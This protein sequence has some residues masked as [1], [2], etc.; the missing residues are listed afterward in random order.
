MAKTKQQF[1][2][3]CAS[4]SVVG[5]LQAGYTSFP[6][7]G[8]VT[9][10]I[11]K[12]EA[13]LGVSVTG[14]MNN[15]MLFDAELLEEG[16]RI[17]KQTNER[18]AKMIGINQAARTTCVKPSGNASVV[19]G[20]ASGIHPEHSEKYFRIMQL[21][22][23]NDTAKWLEENMPILL[24]DS[25]WS[26]NKTDYAVFIPIENPKEGLYKKDVKGVKHLELIKLEIGRAHV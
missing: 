14:W 24:E 22:K 10:D 11:V 13:L 18:V 21:N 20:T 15:P 16:A 5:T 12:G 19:L 9:E 1:L 17:V 6:Y 3:I 23:D 8:K 26:S 7:L 4:A 25:H 2:D